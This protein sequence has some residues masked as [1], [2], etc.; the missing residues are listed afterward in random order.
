MFNVMAVLCCDVLC[1]AALLIWYNLALMCLCT[2]GGMRGL[3][4]VILGV[5]CNFSQYGIC[6]LAVYLIDAF[7][8]CVLLLV[9]ACWFVSLLKYVIWIYVCMNLWVYLIASISFALFLSSF[10]LYFSNS[11]SL[12]L[13]VCGRSMLLKPVAWRISWRDTSAKTQTRCFSHHKFVLMLILSLIVWATVADVFS[14]I[15]KI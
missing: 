6:F 7:C 15:H 1:C 2:L 8:F 4:D 14:T 10:Y 13:C 12:F 3:G 11:L 9:A 5:V